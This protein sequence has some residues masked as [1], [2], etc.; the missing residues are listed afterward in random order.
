MGIS[1]KYSVVCISCTK[2]SFSASLLW[3][4][5]VVSVDALLKG[6]QKDVE[7]STHDLSFLLPP[8]LKI[9]EVHV[10]HFLPI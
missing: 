9:K 10:D 7:L 2:A 3:L 5:G 4:G 6:V 8:H 1:S